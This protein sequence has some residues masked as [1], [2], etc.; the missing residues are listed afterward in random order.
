MTSISTLSEFLQQAGTEYRVYDI[1]RGIRYLSEQVFA[2]IEHGRRPYPFPRQAHAWLGIVFWNK[3]L[4]NEH[5][6]W[7]LKFALDETSTLIN[8]PRDHFLHLVVEALEKE[9]NNNSDTLS[10]VENP[11]SFVP[12]QQTLAD[13]NALTKV[14]LGIA[15]S[16]YYQ[17]T[18][19]FLKAPSVMNWQ[20]LST[21]GLADFC[22]RLQDASNGQL[23]IQTYPQLAPVVQNS[24]L[25]SLENYQLDETLA[26]TLV[27]YAKSNPEDANLMALTLRALA[28]SQH[29]SIVQSYVMDVIK[30]KVAID[31]NILS[32]IVA[33]HWQLLIDEPILTLLL[34]R[35][36]T[37][38][39][40]VCAGLYKDLVM[41]PLMRQRMLNVLNRETKNKALAECLIQLRGEFV[42]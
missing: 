5:Y 15:P 27:A 37:I 26:L 19:R 7:F 3:N 36:A 16:T 8:G 21:Q 30:N 33:R 39:M 32:V 40:E 41:I 24:L 18:I 13:F 42:R 6:L 11:Y 4:S 12:S 22:S 29:H 34:E 35:A 1:G 9:T 31:I 2:D 17:E 25:S 38:N 14:E 23:L 28:Q 20:Q 10:K